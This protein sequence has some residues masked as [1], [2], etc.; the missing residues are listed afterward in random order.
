MQDHRPCRWHPGS[1]KKVHS[2]AQVSPLSQAVRG[3]ASRSGEAHN[4][5]ETLRSTQAGRASA[6][7]KNINVS[8]VGDKSAI[9]MFYPPEYVE[10]GGIVAKSS[11]KPTCPPW[12]SLGWSVLGRIR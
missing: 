1:T 12:W 2:V 3:C 7:N 9:V 11:G 6:D 4:V 8:E 10:A 5:V